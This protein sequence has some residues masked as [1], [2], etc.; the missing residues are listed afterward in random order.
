MDTQ[1]KNDPRA[2]TQPLYLD[3]D[4][5]L[6]DHVTYQHFKDLTQ[7]LKQDRFD[8]DYGGDLG[9]A[10]KKVKVKKA[11]PAKPLPQP[12]PAVIRIDW[13][14][15]RTFYYVVKAGGFTEAEGYLYTSQSS[16]S[17][18]IQKLEKMLGKRLIVRRTARPTSITTLTPTGTM[19][20]AQISQGAE[21]FEA[22]NSY[23]KQNLKKKKPIET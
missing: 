13:N 14:Y 16:I 19:I 21:S 12:S 1:Y 5:N 6:S 22:L 7:E 18:I 4:D 3:K 2:L 11:R 8:Y 20:M 10:P 23:V 17:R 15:W 9:V